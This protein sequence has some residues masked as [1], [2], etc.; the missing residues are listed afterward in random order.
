MKTKKFNLL[1]I[2]DL[3]VDINNFKDRFGKYFN[4]FTAINT[5]GSLN[6]LQQEN[7]HLIISGQYAPKTLL[8]KSKSLWPHINCILLSDNLPQKRPAELN[9]WWH[10]SKSHN[11][12]DLKLI[13]DKAIANTL[14]KIENNVLYTKLNTRENTLDQLLET[15]ID[16]VLTIDENHKIIKANSS[17]YKIFSYKKDFLINKSLNLLIPKGSRKSH[18]KHI[19][20]FHNES[21]LS[22][23]VNQKNTELFGLTSKG[24]KVPIEIT[25]SKQKT[26]SGFHYNAFIKDITERRKAEKKIKDSEERFSLALK[27]ANDGLFDRNVTKNTVYFSPRWKEMLGY[28]DI[29]IPNEF[30][31]WKNLIHSDDREKAILTVNKFMDSTN[32]SMHYESKFRLRHKNGSYRHILARGY[33][34]RAKT[35]EV[36]RIVGTHIDLTDQIIAKNKLRESE[37]RL[38]ESQKIASLGSFCF[39][40]KTKS[41]TSSIVLD[42]IIGIN[43]NHPKTLQSWLNIFH[44]DNRMNIKELFSFK[45]IEIKTF[46]EEFKINRFNDKEERWLQCI[47]ELEFDIKGNPLSIIGTLQDI[48][49]RKFAE[50]T[51]SQFKHI[52]SNSNDMI[53]YIN[54]DFKY[55]VVN[56]RYANAFQR[57]PK[58]IIGKT[59]ESVLGTDFFN[60]VF[61]VNADK[62]LSGEKINYT[63]WFDLP[64][65]G[66]RFIKISY[67]PY[68]ASDKK[69]QGIIVNGRD[70]TEEKKAEDKIKELNKNL[71]ALVTQKKGELLLE[72]SFSDSIINSLPGI[73]SLFDKNGKHVRWNKNHETVTGYSFEEYKQMSIFELF[74]KENKVN[75]LKAL[76]RLD[77]TDEVNIEANILM[78]NKEVIPYYFT[79]MNVQIGN[80]KYIAGMGIDISTRKKTETELLQKTEELELFN[81]VM[82]E[83]E[84]RVIEM[85]EEVNKLSQQLGCEAPYP[86]IWNNKN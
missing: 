69:T 18:A 62:C 35:G 3:Q 58:E 45:D 17:V 29:E 65:Y 52:V 19:N 36:T 12:N 81:K 20:F 11:K 86:T 6:V 79:G 76:S 74:A 63:K 46:N 56:N 53:A 42:S 23:N 40:A 9:V 48:T 78:K 80:E 32:K 77:K 14:L 83:R 84:M 4:V 13:I 2:D 55:V 54:D 16:G 50:N 72:K 37:K 34:E 51:L 49:E 33:G 70:I 47:G 15:T 75:L 26:S 59:I 5:K 41:W 1:Y 10:V 67:T 43:K 57:T 8:L 25:I 28:K 22:R 30:E 24:E 38:K 85:K 61:K 82:I 7:I 44:P 71:K 64:G 73:F 68:I 21:V 31:S 27:G 66:K 39:N 60:S